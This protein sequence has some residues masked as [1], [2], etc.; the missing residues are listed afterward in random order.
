MLYGGLL[1]RLRSGCRRA[2]TTFMGSIPGDVEVPIEVWLQ[3][4]LPFIAI[5]IGA[6]IAGAY[7]RVRWF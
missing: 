1:G 3:T 6:A 7:S 2:V 4:M 5:G